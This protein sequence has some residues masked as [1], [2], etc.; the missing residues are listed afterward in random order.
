MSSISPQTRSLAGNFVL[1][2]DNC[3][4]KLYGTTKANKKFKQ[5]KKFLTMVNFVCDSSYKYFVTRVTLL[6]TTLSG[7][8]RSPETTFLKLKIYFKLDVTF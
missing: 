2:F 1:P 4:P 7:S 6:G 5:L 8:S 3:V